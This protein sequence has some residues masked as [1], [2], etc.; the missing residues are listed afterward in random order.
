[1]IAGLFGGEFADRR[2]YP[3]SI[4]SQHDDV[5]G[6]TID[7]ARNFGIG[8][9]LDRVCTACIFGNTDIVVIRVTVKRY[10]DDVLKDRSESDGVENVRFFLGG[11][12]D[13]FGIASSFNVEYA[14]VGPDVLVIADEEAAGVCG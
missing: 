8:N 4:A 7:K 6:L 3:E 11:E 12:V 13:A 10:V 14:G 9:E 5:G 1:V 2:Q